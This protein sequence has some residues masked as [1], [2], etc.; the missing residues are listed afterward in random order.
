MADTGEKVIFET[1]IETGNHGKL[2]LEKLVLW[3]YK[4]G[5]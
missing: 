3:L 5:L 2:R 4:D 1:R